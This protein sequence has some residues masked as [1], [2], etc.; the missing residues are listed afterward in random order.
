MRFRACATS[1]P[2]LH[3]PC[4][5]AFRARDAMQGF[6]ISREESSEEGAM[7]EPSEPLVPNEHE[8]GVA[9]ADTLGAH[10]PDNDR[11]IGQVID[12]K[13]HVLR[14]LACGG[15]GS[16]YEARHAVVGRHVAL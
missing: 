11:R 8:L 1:R 13:Y 14:R 9:P 15:M 3:C 5:S 7:S 12:G 16:V 6:E 4:G 2:G 10:A